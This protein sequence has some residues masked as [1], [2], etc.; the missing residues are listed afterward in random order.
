MEPKYRTLLQAAVLLVV[1]AFVV[2][3]HGKEADQDTA[4]VASAAR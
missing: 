2:H 3:V 1:L 4:Q